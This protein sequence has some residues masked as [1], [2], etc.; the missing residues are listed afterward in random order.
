MDSKIPARMV[1]PMRYIQMRDLGIKEFSLDECLLNEEKEPAA[2]D[3]E[4]LRRA[5]VGGKTVVHIH[6]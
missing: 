6:C 2:L 4:G 3:T 1:S 5:F